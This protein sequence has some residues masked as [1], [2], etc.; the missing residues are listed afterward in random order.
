MSISSGARTSSASRPPA[1]KQLPEES[2]DD[3]HHRG[4]IQHQAGQFQRSRLN[5]PCPRESVLAEMA[6]MRLSFFKAATSR[7]CRRRQ[8]IATTGLLQIHR[9]LAQTA[10]SLV[11]S[12][13]EECHGKHLPG[14]QVLDAALRLQFSQRGVVLNDV[15]HHHPSGTQAAVA[16]AIVP[17]G[18]PS[19]R[20]SFGVPARRS[21][22]RD[23]RRRPT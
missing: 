6:Q 15:F 14:R 10:P 9:A 2:F 5:A 4:S 3:P 17:E 12:Q 21:A 13:I 19:E 20:P 8:R 23:R 11:G 18:S 7:A 1:G 16:E 22:T